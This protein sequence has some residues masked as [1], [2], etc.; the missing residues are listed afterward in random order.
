VAAAGHKELLV[1]LL[2]ELTSLETILGLISLF[3]LKQL[4]IVRLEEA[5]TEEMLGKSM[6]LLKAMVSLKKAAKTISLRILII[7]HALPFKNVL[8]A[9]ILRVKNPET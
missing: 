3:H 5:A 6:P 4:S 8:I 9:L 2:T 7:F 1:Q